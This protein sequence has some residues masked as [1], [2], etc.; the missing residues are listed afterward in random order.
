[1]TV[2]C[3]PMGYIGYYIKKDKWYGYLILLPIIL[4]TLS[5]YHTYL[6]Y[7][8]FNYPNYFLISIFC[9]L[10]SIIYPI[11]LFNNKKIKIVGSLISTILVIIITASVFKEPYVYTTQFLSTI[12]DKSLTNE[13]HV[14]LE[15]K[16]YGDIYIEY[17]ESIDSY[18]I[19]CDFKKSGKTRLIVNTPEG[20]TIKY[21]LI[22][23]H[24]TYSLKKE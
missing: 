20:K 19:H 8:T 18:I 7:F 21:K 16:K 6:L 23:K 22:I 2:L 9:I 3:L 5:S 11:V 13:Y 1:M 12:D 4:L 15:N 14:K 17:L 10:A 24:D